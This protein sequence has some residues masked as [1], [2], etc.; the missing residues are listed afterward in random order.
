MTDEPDQNTDKTVPRGPT[1][2]RKELSLRVQRATGAK[3]KDVRLILEATLL[4]M[5]DALK[6]GE[7]LRLP[8]FGAARVLRAADPESGQSMR[9]A[10]RELKEKAP[11]P[12]RPVRAPAAPKPARPAKTARPVAAAKAA[13]G[14]KAG[15]AP[16]AKQA[17]AAKDEAD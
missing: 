2:T 10:L 11:N 15:R 7:H 4:A 13:K 1:V 9:V 12:N 14:A 5:S 3:L 6:A 8:P 16:K 17:L